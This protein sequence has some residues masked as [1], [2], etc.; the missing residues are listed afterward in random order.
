MTLLKEDLEDLEADDFYILMD[1]SNDEINLDLENK[2]ENNDHCAII[3]V[4][5]MG[6]FLIALI[7]IFFL[8]FH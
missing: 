8:N 4:G 6:G 5:C 3:T 1:Y 7:I 2:N